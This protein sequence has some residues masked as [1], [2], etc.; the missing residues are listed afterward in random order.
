M[1]GIR[2]I[3]D[4]T[5]FAT[6]LE[7]VLFSSSHLWAIAGFVAFLLSPCSLCLHQK[8]RALLWLNVRNI[9]IYIYITLLKHDELF[10]LI[11]AIPT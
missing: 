7:K 8:M 9:Y 5:W 10:T 2:L 3:A 11:S 1:E 4:S 6:L